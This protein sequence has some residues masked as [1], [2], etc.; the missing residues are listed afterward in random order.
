MNKVCFV[1]KVVFCALQW[2]VTIPST[3]HDLNRLE[4]VSKKHVQFN[5][6]KLKRARKEPQ[7]KPLVG[8]G[9]LT[10]KRITTQEA[11]AA[12]LFA[13]LKPML[14]VIPHLNHLAVL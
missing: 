10:E 4:I 12:V 9:N 11:A 8:L 13:Q 5:N 6:E 2:R 7:I 14:E 3:V 1:N